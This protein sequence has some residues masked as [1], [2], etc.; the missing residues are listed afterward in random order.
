MSL[1]KEGN[2]V[3][4]PFLTGLLWVWCLAGSQGWEERLYPPP[5]LLL[6]A[7]VDDSSQPPHLKDGH[8]VGTVPGFWVQLRGDSF[9]PQLQLSVC[10]LYPGVSSLLCT[11]Q[12]AL[13]MH[14]SSV[15]WGGSTHGSSVSSHAK[16]LQNRLGTY[17][18]VEPYAYDKH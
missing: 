2:A 3:G 6:P 18:D 5:P 12:G 4:I 1:T 15:R 13:P 10:F 9:C 7:H 14:G 8:S 16:E 17:I 11:L